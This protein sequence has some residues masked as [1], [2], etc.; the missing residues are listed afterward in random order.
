MKGKQIMI[1]LDSDLLAWVDA[2]ADLQHTTRAQWV[3]ERLWEVRTAADSAP[4]TRKNNR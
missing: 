3:R 4:A 2:Q 1:R